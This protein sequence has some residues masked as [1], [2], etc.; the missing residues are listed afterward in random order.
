SWATKWDDLAGEI[1]SPEA[2]RKLE[3]VYGSPLNVD[4]FPAIVLEDRVDD[5]LVGPT[6]RCVLALQFRA[7][8]D[9]DRFQRIISNSNYFTDIFCSFSAF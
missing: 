1:S 5:S 3:E 2:L 6:A 8:R 9:G 4:L 7:L